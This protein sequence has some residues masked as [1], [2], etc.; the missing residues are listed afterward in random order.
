MKSWERAVFVPNSVFFI[1]IASLKIDTLNR[2]DIEAV[3]ILFRDYLR[4]NFVWIFIWGMQVI[5]DYFQLSQMK[6]C[7]KEPQRSR[8]YLLQQRTNSFNKIQNSFLLCVVGRFACFV[9]NSFSTRTVIPESFFEWKII[10]ENFLLENP[11]AWTRRYC[12]PS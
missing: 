1:I 4:A 3:W 11:W 10:V 6:S 2:F 8:N 5:V 12:P 9:P 7:R